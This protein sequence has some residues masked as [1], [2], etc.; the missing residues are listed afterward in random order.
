MLSG[1]LMNPDMIIGEVIS[2]ALGVRHGRRH[3][4]H[5]FDLIVGGHP[6]WLNGGTLMTALGIAWGMLDTANTAT[7]QTAP[8]TATMGA[9][10]SAASASPPRS[11]APVP[12]APT[13]PVE[14]AR[15]IRLTVS[16]ARADGALTDIEQD[17]I[18]TR[19]RAVGAEPLV[20]EELKTPTPLSR[21]V[22]GVPATSRNELY[23]LA[24]AIVHADG[25]IAGAERIYLAQLAHA[26][27]L[28]V[29]DAASLE[30]TAA[31]R[32]NAPAPA[33][34]APVQE[35]PAAATPDQ[36]AASPEVS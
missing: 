3:R 27:G 6:W 28:S 17:A 13:V 11:D 10:Q 31:E 20:D 32:L 33:G 5:P 4:H 24:F 8:S 15:V 36:P 34:D 23:S 1:F 30:Q 29:E 14:V 21:L 26:L 2:S 9:S 35:A 19:A 7:V 16:A 25:V 18:R 22:A 12:A